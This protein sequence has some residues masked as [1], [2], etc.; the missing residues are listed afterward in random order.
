MVK[1]RDHLKRVRDIILFC[2]KTTSDI[3]N[4]GGN[5]KNRLGK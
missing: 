3:E 5:K 2:K 4:T 1:L